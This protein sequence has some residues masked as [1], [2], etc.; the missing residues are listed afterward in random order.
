MGIVASQSIRNTIITY[1]GFG[2]GAVNTLFLYANFLTD[3]YFGLV[4]FLL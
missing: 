3:D 1:L 2:I 4:V